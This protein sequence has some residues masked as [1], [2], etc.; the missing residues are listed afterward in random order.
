MGD[1]GKSPDWNA[2]LVKRCFVAFIVG[3]EKGISIL[4]EAYAKCDRKEAL[5]DLIDIASIMVCMSRSMIQ[6]ID[7]VN[8]RDNSGN[9]NNKN[10]LRSLLEVCESEMKNCIQAKKLCDENPQLGFSGEGQGTVRG[11]LFNAYTVNE[12]ISELNETISA[13]KEKL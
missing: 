11:G 10:T 4:K 7:F 12:K 8:L 9:V 5:K 1:Y 13:I 2:E 3:F 6:F